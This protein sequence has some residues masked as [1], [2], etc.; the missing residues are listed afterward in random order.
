MRPEELAARLGVEVFKGKYPFKD[1]LYLERA[2]TERENAPK[3]RLYTAYHGRR[4][5]VDDI[6]VSEVMRGVN[7]ED[8]SCREK[9]YK[10]LEKEVNF[11]GVEMPECWGCVQLTS[12][13]LQLLAE[14]SLKD[15]KIV[16]FP[17][18]ERELAPARAFHNKPD[19]E[20]QFVVDVCKGIYD[21]ELSIRLW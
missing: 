1:S 8:A 20:K 3:I 18:C 13:L 5:Y 15:K 10:N 19:D 11:A 17:D 2:V 4:H 9:F 12:E 6:Y 7:F 16:F 21:D 14:G